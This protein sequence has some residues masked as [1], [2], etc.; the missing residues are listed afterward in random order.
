MDAFQG[1]KDILTNMGVPPAAVTPGAFLV[2]NLELDSLEM[3]QLTQELEEK[4]QVNIS[5]ASM[6]GGMTVGD[7]VTLIQ[8]LRGQ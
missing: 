7:L 3:V 2:T 6:H 4:F 8:E 1:V 5:D